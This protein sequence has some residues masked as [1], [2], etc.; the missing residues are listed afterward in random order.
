MRRATCS[1]S[2]LCVDIYML[3]AYYSL[4]RGFLCYHAIF[5]RSSRLGSNLRLYRA[6]D[7]YINKFIAYHVVTLRLASCGL[8]AS[9][10]R[11]S[12]RTLSNALWNPAR[13]RGEF[14]GKL[15][16]ILRIGKPYIRG[17]K[18]RGIIF[19]WRKILLQNYEIMAKS[20]ANFWIFTIW[21]LK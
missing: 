14:W 9:C 10:S 6:L 16:S 12:I 20:Q 2:S 11:Y 3:W 15:I 1:C 7:E 13:I 4:I 21:F 19:L 8:V 17:Y 5:V 18:N